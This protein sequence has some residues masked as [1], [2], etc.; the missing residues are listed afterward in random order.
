MLT[1]QQRADRVASLFL[2]AAH[3]QRE[4]LANLIRQE[5]DEASAEAVELVR[6]LASRIDPTAN[7][8]RALFAVAKEFLAARGV[9]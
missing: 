5:L 7:G 1:S 4:V 6:Q 8:S 2:G 3:E 9:R